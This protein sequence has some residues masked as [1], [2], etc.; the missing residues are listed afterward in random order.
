M[1]IL[2]PDRIHYD[3]PRMAGNR[4]VQLKKSTW[5]DRQVVDRKTGRAVKRV[6]EEKERK[7]EKKPRQEGFQ[8]Q[9]YHG[10]H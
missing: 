4:P 6:V 10:R 8:K 5:D 2:F 9:Y 3:L 1:N 7:P